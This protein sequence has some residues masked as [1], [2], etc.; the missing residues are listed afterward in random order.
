MNVGHLLREADPL[1]DETVP[2]EARA[3]LRQI[4]AKYAASE[5]HPERQRH[6]LGRRRLMALAAL[7]VVITGAA[8]WSRTSLQAAV[9]FE[10]R[11]AEDHPVPGVT[12]A[13]VT[14]SGNTVYVYGDAVVTNDDIQSGTVV[15]SDVPGSFGVHVE[16][17]PDGAQ[18]MLQATGANIGHLMAILIDGEVVMAPIIRSPVATVGL[19]SGTYS[20]SE[21]RRIVEGIR[22]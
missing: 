7:A 11:L 1:R 22:R 3:E 15:A 12:P 4:L 21:A 18:K 19:I 8:L 6:V 14:A 5:T 9:R 10:I 17:T 20:Y 13:Y 2:A 16:F